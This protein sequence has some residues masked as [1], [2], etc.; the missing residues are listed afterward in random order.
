MK[1]WERWES[2]AQVQL[3]LHAQPGSG[4]QWHRPS[5]GVSSGHY[6]EV[7]WPL[8]IDCKHTG[9]KSYSVVRKFM[10]QW[11]DK[12]LA[13]GKHF[14]LPIRFETPDEGHSDFVVI[15]MDD[16]VELVALANREGTR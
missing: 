8:M 15:T 12:A 11:L 10:D 7:P 2:E 5:D 13:S 16:Y 1:L 3:G 6:T 14:A 4:N 9:R